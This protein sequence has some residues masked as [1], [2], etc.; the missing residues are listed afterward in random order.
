MFNA[1]GMNDTRSPRPW[2]RPPAFP[3]SSYLPPLV[4]G[5]LG[6]TAAVIS[7]Q[8]QTIPVVNPSFELTT[9]N[10]NTAPCLL[11]GRLRLGYFIDSLDTYGL[12]EAC[13]DPDPLPGWRIDRGNAGVQYGA[14]EATDGTNIAYANGGR[15]TQTLEEVLRPGAYTLQVDIG[16]RNFGPT[17]SGYTIE[18]RAGGSQ[19]ARSA[20]SVQP[21]G[22]SFLTDT[23]TVVVPPDHPLLGRPVQ[24]RLSGPSQ[25]NFDNVRL[26][27]GHEITGVLD[28]A[29]GQALIS[30]G[31][32]VSVFGNF[33]ESTETASSI[34]LSENL[35]GFS[36]T[37]NDTPGALFGV[38]DGEFDQS[39]VQVPWNVDVS[40]GKVEVKVHW[41][42]ET[43][44][45][46][47]DP[48]EVDAALASPGIY[49]FPP[50]TT[51]AIVTNFKQEGDDVTAGSWAQASGSIDP[52]AGQPAAIGGVVTIWCDGLGPVSPE[53]PTGDIPPAGTVP[54][55]NKTVRVFVG[56]VEAQVLG[57]VLQPTSVGLN[58]IN[59]IV[60]NGVTPGDAVPIVIEVECPDGTK[61]R[62]REDV[63]IAVRAAP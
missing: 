62:S 55:T 7:G 12:S 6:M 59:I 38:F 17:L 33:V 9:E 22:G 8:S 58:Q 63:T 51:Q 49:M 35:G 36:F 4:I 45:V 21:P 28:A 10:A 2:L 61:L 25:A 5:I 23:L 50:G 47:S 26:H 19:I 13:V 16:D 41:K 43:S 42:D 3:R 15:L 40:S 56:G 30:P 52:V 31:A 37:F 24:I 57:S 44:E 39:N 54:V 14:I 32:I 53:P 48:F 27:G 11:N 1:A 29:G 18:L 20:D 46:W 60:P 34:P